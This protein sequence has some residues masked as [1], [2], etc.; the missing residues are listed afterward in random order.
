MKDIMYLLSSKRNRDRLNDAI[1]QIDN[2]SFTKNPMIAGFADR[3][4]EDY[5]HWVQ[6]DKKYSKESTHFW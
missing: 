5:Q 4:W 2:L 6:T 3:C 1:D